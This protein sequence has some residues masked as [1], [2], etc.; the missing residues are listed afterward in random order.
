MMLGAKQNQSARSSHVLALD[1]AFRD[2]LFIGRFTAK[3]GFPSRSPV[4]RWSN[5]S[6]RASFLAGYQRGYQDVIGAPSSNH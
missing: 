6:D 4:G 3:A 2:G 1:G 5:D